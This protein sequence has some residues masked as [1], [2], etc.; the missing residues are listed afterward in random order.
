MILIHSTHEA[1]FKVG[2]IGA[3]LD[4]LLSAPS[5]LA[6]VERT[7]LVGP[8]NTADAIEMERLFSPR[9]RLK[10]RYFS[11]GNQYD[12]SP[13]L[14]AKLSAIEARWKA[15]LLYG[16]RGFGAAEHEIIL[17]DPTNIPREQL[18]L[19][20]YLAWERFGLNSA[21]YEKEYEYDLYMA[22]APAA[23]EAL[24]TILEIRDW[25]LE[26]GDSPRSISDLAQYSG[27]QSPIS[28]S[29]SPFVICHEF[30]GLPLWYAAETARPG[31]LKSAYVAHEVPTARLLVEAD[32]G[33]DT[34][35]YNI[36]HLAQKAGLT[37]DEVFGDQSAFHKDGMVKTAALCDYVLAVGDPVVDELRFLDERFRRKPIDIVYNGAPSRQVFLSATSASNQKLKTYAHTLT[38]MNPTFIFSHV[39]RLVTSK[40]LWRD[41]RVMEALDPL[42]AERGESAAL[43]MLT[44]VIPQGRS[45]AEAQRMAREYGW[46]RDHREGWPDLIA[47][48]TPL[49]HAISAF[50][51]TARASRIVFIN[52]FGFSRDRCGDTMPADMTFDD[53]RNGTD[54]EFGQSIYEPFGIAQVEPLSAGALCVVSDVCGCLG[55]VRRK[56][57]HSTEFLPLEQ[58]GVMQADLGEERRAFL[59]VLVADYTTLPTPLPSSA[60]I[61]R[62]AMNIGQVERDSVEHHTAGEV[63]EAIIERLPRNELQKQELID[64]GYHLAQQMSWDVI[65]REQLIPAITR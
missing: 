9:N 27:Q 59:N 57:E 34:R 12:C 58:T 8:M 38:G 40:G 48:E 37:M 17:V 10:V 24:Q 47:Y 61:I 31:M 51:A 43:I 13:E 56:L 26:I 36:L 32:G 3:V 29:Q 46:P 7:L 30:M 18:G 64:N 2:G 35:F 22:A 19:F 50:N 55:F 23:F 44:S 25:R 39:T 63:A 60:N 6:D 28:S 52:Q 33:H 11:L 62:T 49:W 5:Y 1:G 53:L 15:R 45:A 16:T 42:L 14:A 4:G 65:A 54:L 21:R 41:L 20:K